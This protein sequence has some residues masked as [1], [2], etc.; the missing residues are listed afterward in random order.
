MKE[1]RAGRA[2]TAPPPPLRCR[3]PR[4]PAARPPGPLNAIAPLQRWHGIAI[5]VGVEAHHPHRGGTGGTVGQGAARHRHRVEAAAD[6][7]HIRVG[8]VGRW[9]S[10]TPRGPPSHL[11]HPVRGGQLVVAVHREVGVAGAI[12]AGPGPR[13]GRIAVRVRHHLDPQ[14]EVFPQPEAG[15]PFVNNAGAVDR[16]WPVTKMVR[17]AVLGE[18]SAKRQLRL[19][20]GTSPPSM[21]AAVPS[22]RHRPCCTAWRWPR[23]SGRHDRP[24]PQIL[25]GTGSR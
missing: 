21:R 24:G 17:L 4:S 19:C 18:R 6:H 12:A 13:P 25:R 7:P 15:P 20:G 8:Q 11:S 16:A 2:H 5:R 1:N 3:R 10:A 9:D 14:A 23:C 22:D